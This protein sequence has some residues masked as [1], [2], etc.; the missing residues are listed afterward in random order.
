MVKLNWAHRRS[1]GRLH[2][3]SVPFN[4][5]KSHHGVERGVVSF[6]NQSAKIRLDLTKDTF[7]DSMYFFTSF[8]IVSSHHQ[9]SISLAAVV[10]TVA[11]PVRVSKIHLWTQV[12]SVN[13]CKVVVFQRIAKFIPL[14]MALSSVRLICWES[15]SGC[16]Q[17]ASSTTAPSYTSDMP[18]VRELASTHMLR[19]WPC[20][21][22]LVH[23][24]ENLFNHGVERGVVSFVIPSSSDIRCSPLD[25]CH[26]YMK[27]TTHA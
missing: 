2:R 13:K 3:S 27:P 19:A 6:V 1:A 22:F 16:N 20:R 12:E 14:V 25:E 9:M 23:S 8:I 18:V 24:D 26:S 7:I 11:L 21:V 17:Q 15:F 5:I 10:R 4:C